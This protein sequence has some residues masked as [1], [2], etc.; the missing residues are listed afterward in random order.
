M[1]LVFRTVAIFAFILFVTRVT[2]RHLRDPARLAAE[3]RALGAR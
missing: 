3:L 2:G 1:D